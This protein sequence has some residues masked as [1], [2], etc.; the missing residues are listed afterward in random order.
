MKHIIDYIK[1]YPL[2]L[3]LIVPAFL[4]YMLIIFRS[5]SDYCFSGKCGIYFWGVHGH[6]GIWHL[7]VA[8]TAF[9]Q[10]PFS[11]P[12]FA[13]APLTG[14]NYLLDLIIYL[15][16]F[17]RI[18][19]IISYFKILPLAWFAAF[20]ILLIALGRRIK[21]NPVFVALFLFF[22]YF[23]GSFS[24]F[25]TLYHDRTIWGSAGLLANLNVH[26]MS[27]PPFAF[28]LLIMLAI[29][30]IVK[31][32]KI[33]TRTAIVLGLLNFLN[34]GLKF[35]GGAVTV[36]LTGTYI[37]F[38]QIKKDKKKL[39]FYAFIQLIFVVAA[40]L[41]FY[42]P[43][44]S[45]KTGA[46]FT[47]APFALIHTITE[48]PSLFYLR[49]L[50]DARYFLASRGIGPK[51]I[52][53]EFFNLT[54]FTFFYL[55]VKFFGLVYI[56]IKTIRRKIT[57]LDFYILLT[58]IFATT[59]TVTLVQKAEWWNI[60][61]FFYYVIFL[62]AVFAAEMM[63]GLWQ[64]KRKFIFYIFAGLIILLSLP[65]S[66]D[67]AREYSAAPGAAYVP[68][69]E[70][71]AL[72]YLKKQPAGIVYTPLY[73]KALQRPTGPNELYRYEDTAYVAAFT[74]KPVYFANLLQLRLTG[75]DYAARLKK[76]QS[77]DC[78]ILNEVDYI[79]EIRGIP[80]EG[81]LLRCGAEKVR[82]IFDNEAVF[83]YAVIK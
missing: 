24:Y 6:D 42:D 66:L 10:I 69:P 57:G 45:L 12:T 53:I 14:Y 28:S 59:L 37:F 78:R 68:T 83:I 56:G 44:N 38:T 52:L 33:D 8:N 39:I 58:M 74:G 18:P 79:Y 7:A 34:L 4:I 70:L 16:S 50:T 73:D 26:T 55:G 64:T 60:V 82:R 19:A 71:A 46:V 31:K 25:F 11:S 63:Y 81:K 20:T 1:K 2:L 51:L 41:F 36:F 76:M 23:S 72:S 15:L 13:G 5:G 65:A 9:N 3:F 17:L 29:L 32:R 43:F 40:I 61:Q 67:V 49:K 27:N 30:L 77:T 47:V 62:S 21:N 54:V 35:Y 80:Q 22:A 75:V 48:E